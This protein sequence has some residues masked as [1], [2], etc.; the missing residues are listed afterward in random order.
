MCFSSA[1]PRWSGDEREGARLGKSV[2]QLAGPG[3][4]ALEMQGGAA[5]RGRDPS[6]HM[7]Q[8]VTQT[9][10]LFLGQGASSRTSPWVK[11]IKSWAIKTS[12]IQQA[13][14]AKAGKGKFLSPVVLG[15][16]DAVL[17]PGMTPVPG[18]QV[19]DVGIGRIGYEH[20]VPVSERIEEVEGGA[21][22]RQLSAQ[23]HARAR[24]PTRLVDPFG[25]LGHLGFVSQLHVGVHR[26][27]RFDDS[28][29][30]GEDLQ[31]S[32]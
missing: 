22:V 31:A 29:V 18:F 7:Q 19:G 2:G 4:L 6:G 5:P 11:A 9:L 24:G 28:A 30:I 26:L 10:G 17:H 3:P 12:S 16:A 13:L 23:D 14:L 25:E 20:L 21:G 27:H 15:A 1:L 32:L 8:R